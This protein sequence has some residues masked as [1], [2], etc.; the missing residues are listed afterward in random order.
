MEE[1]EV[2]QVVQGDPVAS[3]NDSIPI[4]Q[5]PQQETIE[6]EEKDLIPS[7]KEEK[8]AD[9]AIKEVERALGDSGFQQLIK[10]AHE[11]K[12][13]YKQLESVFL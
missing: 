11:L 3:V 2:R 8:E 4:L 13:K 10:N 5:Y 7:T 6:I 9:K 1:G 12:D